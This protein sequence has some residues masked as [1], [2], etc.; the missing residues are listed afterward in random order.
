MTEPISNLESHIGHW[1]RRVSNHVSHRFAARLATHGVT[2]AEWVVM[3]ELYDAGAV[4]PSALAER[5][6]MTRGAITK[7]VDRLR[8]KRLVVRASAGGTDRRFQTI[9]LTGGGARLV[10]D[11]AAVADA[12]DAETF[13]HLSATERRKL[14]ELLRALVERARIAAIPTE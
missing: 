11:L 9:A 1:L 12:N 5:I 3:R 10:P 6:G 4:A 13:S 2:V 8:A 7:L 14:E